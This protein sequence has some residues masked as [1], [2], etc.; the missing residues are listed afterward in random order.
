MRVRVCALI[1]LLTGCASTI[2][3]EWRTLPAAPAIDA[4]QLDAAGNVTLEAKRRAAGDVRVDGGRLLRGDKPLTE[5]FA[6]IDSFDLSDSR[7]EVVFSAKREQSFD[8]GLVALEGSPV[9][10]IPPETVDEVAVQWAPRGNKISYVVRGR[11]GDFIRTVHVPTAFQLATDFPYAR[12]RAV[13]WDPPA[14]KFA[15]VYS[16][17][18]AS[19]RVEV[20][21]Y[22]GGPRRTAIA[23]SVRLD[24]DVT[25]FASDAIVLRPR[26][27]TYNEKL[28]LVVWV[29]DEPFAWSD[30]R[31][32]LLRRARV[33]CVIAKRAPAE[34]LWTVAR[35]TPWIDVARVYVVSAGAV[36]APNATVITA[37]P[38]VPNGRYRRTGAVVAVA[39]AVVQSFAARFIAAELKR[40]S[41]PNGSSR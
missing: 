36:D 20:M 11:G 38:A 7:G 1:L 21:S 9:N 24:V 29:D 41:P 31:A 33:A 39:P 26:D 32:E 10:W 34:E 16:T 35:G 3:N 12:I 27:V 22:Q 13:T 17:P 6:A 15:V 23:P 8:I 14:E 4:V 18:D 40:I 5:A 2:P 28:P 37:D 30:A 19:D 25:S